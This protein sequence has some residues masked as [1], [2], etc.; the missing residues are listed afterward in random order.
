[1][2]GY[3][4]DAF[5]PHVAAL[6]QR[7]DCIADKRIGYTLASLLLADGSEFALMLVNAMLKV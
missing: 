3:S 5:T 2:L 6:V 4:V 7:A 1:M